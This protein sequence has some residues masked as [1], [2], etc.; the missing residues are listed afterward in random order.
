MR[1]TIF[2]ITLAMGL[3][4]ADSSERFVGLPAHVA[5]RHVDLEGAANF[6]DL[7]GY[8]TVDGREVK[9]GMFYRS[10]NLHGLTDGDL[11]RI[12]DLGIRLVCDFRSP[13]EKAKEPDRLPETDPPQVAELEIWDPAMS[14]QDLR[15]RI[16]SGDLEGLDLREVMIQANRSFVTKFTPLYAEMFEWIRRPENL[17]AVVHCTAGKDRA[18]FASALILRVLGVPLETV[19]EDFLLTNVYTADK[20]DRMVWLARAATF[21]RMEEDQLRAVM[22]V[23]RSYL[24]AAFEEIDKQ[25]GSFDTYRREMLGI[26]DVQLAAFR[27]MALSPKL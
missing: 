15:G 3:A 2:L 11:R 6:R 9:W 21:F 26:D 19:Y 1:Y 7:G 24:E 14:G 18:G 25:Y 23:E 5:K 20:I 10:D 13:E 27:K 4:C 16:E 17:P 12:G 8:A 22:G